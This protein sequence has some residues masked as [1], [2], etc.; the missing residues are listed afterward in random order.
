MLMWWLFTMWFAFFPVLLLR[1][2]SDNV[3]FVTTHLTTSVCLLHGIVLLPCGISGKMTIPSKSLLSLLASCS[4]FCYAYVAIPTTCLSCLPY[5]HVKP[6]TH[7]P[8]KP[9]FGYVAA[10]LR[11]FDSVVSCRWSWR[12]LHD[13][14]DYVGISQYLLFN[15][16]A[17]IYLVKGGRHGLMPGVLFHSC[18]P[19]FRHTGVMFL[20]FAFLT[21]LGVMGTPW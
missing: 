9:L 4:L 13:G 11:P 16:N 18:R 14:Q 1:V 20:D 12:L 5:C 15:Y 10:L 21:R 19:S 3:A 6:L 8:S 7:L 2:G 17:S